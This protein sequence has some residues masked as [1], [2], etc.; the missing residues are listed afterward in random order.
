M[1]KLLERTTGI[2]VD[3]Q[4]SYL[5]RIGEERGKLLEAQK[6]MVGFL[7]D[8]NASIVMVEREG[9]GSTICELKDLVEQLPEG[10]REVIEKLDINGFSNPELPR[11]L[12][13]WKAE[14]LVFM[15]VYS[16]QC[17][18]ETIKGA[19]GYSYFIERPEIWTAGPL[20]AIK[21]RKRRIMRTNWDRWY[22][23]N[24]NINYYDIFTSLLD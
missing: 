14:D 3:M 24:E 11:K 6:E 4:E 5:N 15:G 22:R 1:V 19:L 23:D 17:V 12:I 9:R 10:K 18:R 20:I 8:R 13:E 21:E 7:A 16:D 2:I